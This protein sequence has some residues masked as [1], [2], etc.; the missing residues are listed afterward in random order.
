M[1]TGE[2][3]EAGYGKE[4][5]RMSAPDQC[6][7]AGGNANLSGMES[8]SGIDAHRSSR[9]QITCKRGYDGKHKGAAGKRDWIGCA[10]LKQ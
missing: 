4:N 1:S 9:G 6:G 2:M 10:G 7:T 5:K 8:V 3:T